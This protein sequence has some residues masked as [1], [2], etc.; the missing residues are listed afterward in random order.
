MYRG[1]LASMRLF[2]A[3]N[4]NNDTRERLH[5]LCNELRSQSERGSF[6]L[7]ENLH[8]T[9]AF[10]GDCDEKQAIDAKNAM[11]EL[12]FDPFE[13][14]F[15]SL[16]RFKRDGGE[17][18]WAG[19]R[20]NNAL[21]DL[22]QS[23]SKKLI[24]AGFKLD[25]KKYKPHVTL[26]RKVVTCLKPRKIES[27][28][29]T[30]SVVDLMKSERIDGILT[31]T[32]IFRCGKWLDPIVIE[33]YDPEW[34]VE[35]EKIRSYLLPHIDDLIVDIHHVGSTSVV[36]LS[37]K[38]I[39]DFDIEIADIGLFPALKDRLKGLGFR[40]EGDY[41]IVG[42]EAFKRD[43]PDDFK[44][45]HMYVC[46]SDSIEFKHHLYFRDAL[47]ADPLAARKYGELKTANAKKYGNDI[48]AYIDGK[49]EFI[50]SI[51]SKDYSC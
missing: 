40:H 37:A 18:W 7:S 21:L 27:F 6:V 17:I 24:N 20:E 13:L 2:I 33:P 36:G 19:L 35:F 46:A 38:P 11:S 9:L 44:Q 22:Q 29:Q 50:C 4:F 48:D 51:L 34:A 49:A 15:E 43:Y 39:I 31:Y 10:L 3:F 25:S 12:D 23:L 28:G 5:D 8:L 41:G 42:R 30:V 14:C 45:Y 1:G 47:R 16:G 32:S 26:G